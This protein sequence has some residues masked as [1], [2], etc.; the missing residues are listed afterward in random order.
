MIGAMEEMILFWE[1]MI[2]S[3]FNEQFN[4]ESLHLEIKT[5]VIELT[6]ICKD[7]TKTTVLI[8]KGKSAMNAKIVT[9]LFN[10]GV[11]IESTLKDLIHE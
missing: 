2:Q 9:N 6:V 11:T 3:W 10:T 5:D 8:E 1:S 7:K 4:I